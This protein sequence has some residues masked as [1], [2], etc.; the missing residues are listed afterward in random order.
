M[1]HVT[2]SLVGGFAAVAA[3]ALVAPSFDPTATTSASGAAGSHEWVNRG[4]K[5]DRLAAPSPRAEKSTVATVEVIGVHDA[6]IVYR[7]RDGRVLFHTDPLRNVTV[8]SKGFVLPQLTVRETPR[9]TPVPVEAPHRLD[10]A[11]AM[12]IGCEPVASPIAEPTLARLAGR[13]LSQIE[14]PA[15]SAARAGSAT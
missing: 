10:A 15:T 6:A 2:S 13:C 12:P 1:F 3:W 11:P 9:S 4:A 14:H 8:V 7:D 5:G